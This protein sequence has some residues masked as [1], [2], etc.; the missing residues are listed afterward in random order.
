[1]IKV[2]LLTLAYAANLAAILFAAY[3]ENPLVQ[4]PVVVA[5]LG[6]GWVIILSM[7]RVSDGRDSEAP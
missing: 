1:M 6:A 4:I 7:M 2:V 5:G 3:I